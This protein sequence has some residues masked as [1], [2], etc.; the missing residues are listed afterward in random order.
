MAFVGQSAVSGVGVRGGVQTAPQRRTRSGAVV[1]SLSRRDLISFAALTALSPLAA[2]AESAAPPAVFQNPQAAPAAPSKLSGNYQDDAKNILD[3]MNAVCNMKRGTPGMSDSVAEVRREMNDFVA[4][5][6]RN[7]KVNGSTSFNTLYT[8]INTLSGHYASY[9]NNYPVPE[10]RRKRLQQQFSEI[11]R[12][13][14]R[15]R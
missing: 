10:K 4:R 13:L 9:G 12:A 14:K 7:D 6:R 11:D 8:A 15:G 3:N 2:L 1:M 5:Y